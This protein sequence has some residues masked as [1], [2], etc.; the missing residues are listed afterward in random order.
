RYLR[1]PG[2]PPLLGSEHLLHPVF[3]QRHDHLYTASTP[4]VGDI[5]A[6]GETGSFAGTALQRSQGLLLDDVH[7]F[8][9]NLLMEFKAGY[10]RYEVLSLPVNYGKNISQQF[11]IPNANFDDVS[12]GLVPITIAGFRGIGD[13]NF[14]PIFAKNNIF[15]YNGSLTYIHGRHNLK[16][17]ADLRRRQITFYSSNQPRGT[18]NF[19]GNFS[20]DPTSQTVGSGNSFASFL[21]GYPQSTTRGYLLVWPGKR[22]W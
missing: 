2:R 17:G 9:P 8:R 18:Y 6:G 21:L 1:Y 20:N 13:A 15:Q 14:V 4:R 5:E 16:F 19:D 22:T 10:V 3:V 11:G 7:V 12:S